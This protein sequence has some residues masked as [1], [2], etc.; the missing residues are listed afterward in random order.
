MVKFSYLSIMPCILD[1]SIRWEMVSFILWILIP[2]ERAPKYPL[3]R[4]LSGIYSWSGETGGKEKTSDPAGNKSPVVQ[5][6]ANNFT[7]N[8]N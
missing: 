4:R 8:L 2:K 6:T 3:H 5:P 7:S 1:L